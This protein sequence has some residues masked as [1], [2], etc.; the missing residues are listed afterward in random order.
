[1]RP[2][3]NTKKHISQISQGTVAQA[4]KTTFIAAVAIEGA[5]TTPSH[6]K[7]GAIVSACYV[8]LW[9][10]QDSASTIGSYTVILEKVPGVGGTI[11]A[12][13]MAALHDYDNKKNIF[14]TGQG[15]LTPNDG[16]QVPVMR[17][18]YKIPKS[19]QRFG[20]GDTLSVSY[21]NNNVTAIDINHCGLFVYKEQY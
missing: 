12:G 19:K 9:L 5:P 10:S 8:E 2:R 13:D 3:V 11:T 1:M 18:W 21:R 4:T 6:V 14:F 7:E 16:G 20:L 17:Q 15:L